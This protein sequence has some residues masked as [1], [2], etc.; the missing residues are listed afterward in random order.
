MK[1]FVCGAQGSVKSSRAAGI[2]HRSSV[3]G[4]VTDATAQLIFFSPP[5]RL[6]CAVM[7]TS[8]SFDSQRCRPSHMAIV[9]C[10][11]HDRAQERSREPQNQP[12][13]DLA[14]AHLPPYL[15]SRCVRS[16]VS[17]TLVLSVHTKTNP[18]PRPIKTNF[19]QVH[20]GATRNLKVKK[21][22]NNNRK[23]TEPA[24]N[25]RLVCG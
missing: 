17:F 19:V 3:R 18:S 16:C 23:S 11:Q 1:R 25:L 24:P 5:P 2:L 4:Q 6:R 15:D 9:M 14:P 8:A 20:C 10:F 7:T 21:R 22:R 13:H 12:G